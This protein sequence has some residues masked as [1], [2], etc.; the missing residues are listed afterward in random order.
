MIFY[1]KNRE[2]CYAMDD[3]VN[4]STKKKDLP[5]LLHGF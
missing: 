3:T 1:Y 4:S 2:V 5:L